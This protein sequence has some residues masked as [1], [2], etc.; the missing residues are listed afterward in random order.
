MSTEFTADELADAADEL[1]GFEIDNPNLFPVPT[2]AVAVRHFLTAKR[3]FHRYEQA[4][5]GPDSPSIFAIAEAM[6]T[7]F[8]FVP[9]LR[10]IALAAIADDVHQISDGNIV[11]YGI[12]WSK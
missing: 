7:E 11:R 9:E 2:T 12:A 6:A 1:A 3:W 5:P 10:L 8:G 4:T